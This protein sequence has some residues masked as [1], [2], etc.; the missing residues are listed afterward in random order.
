MSTIK[1]LGKEL[2]SIAGSSKIKSRI[3]KARRSLKGSNADPVKALALLDEGLALYA[4]EVRW[5]QKA[6]QELG[7]PLT[8]Y[9]QA[10]KRT[11]GLRLQERLDAEQ[12]E[13]V[14][15]CKSKHQDISLNF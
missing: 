2:G 7:G 1:A 11:V 10:L 5:R 14:A 13:F 4:D 6:S 9:D 3:S 8:E 15:R 12:A